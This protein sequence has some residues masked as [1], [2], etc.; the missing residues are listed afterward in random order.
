MQLCDHG[1]ERSMTAVA[2]DIWICATCGVEHQRR[3]E[4]CAICADERQWV[5]REGQLWT[6]LSELAATG[7]RTVFTVLEPGLLGIAAEPAVGIGQRMH[8]VITP[9]GV[10]LWDPVAFV[11]AQG[12]RRVRACGEVIA[13][14]S[15]HPHM[16]G[17]QVAWSRALGGVPILVCEPDI[18]WV[19]RED[20]AI[21]AWSGTRTLAPGLRLLQLGG[22]FP[23]SCVVHWQDGADGRGVLLSSD[24]LQANPDRASVTFMRS[25]PNRIPLSA[26]VAQRIARALAP[27]RFD[28]LYDNFARCIE[29]DAADVV[30]RSA[31][32]HADWVRGEFDALT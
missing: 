25:F 2:D 30:A 14:A 12:I 31:Q 27:L 11:D 22:H 19:A 6:S 17:A 15:S 23:G 5:P 3:V 26:E 8:C 16:F 4:V 20:T 24:T 1:G 21:S 13:I 10:L 29:A 7:H 32:R 28:R 9:E 18:G